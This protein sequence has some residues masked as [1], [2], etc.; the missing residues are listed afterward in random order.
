MQTLKYIFCA[1][2][3]ID[4]ANGIISGM[5]TR[6]LDNLSRNLSDALK[7]SFYARVHLFDFGDLS[8]SFT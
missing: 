3:I 4:R 1:V 6:P 5:R 7:A 8:L 2:R